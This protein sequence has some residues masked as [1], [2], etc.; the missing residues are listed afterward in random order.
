MAGTPTRPALHS[1]LRFTSDQVITVTKGGANV[2]T[3]S[4]GNTYLGLWECMM[5]I[6]DAVDPGNF[7]VH[8]DPDSYR[9]KFITDAS[10]TFDVSAATDLQA[11]MGL[12]STSYTFSALARPATP[13]S[14]RSTTRYTDHS[15]RSPRSRRSVPAGG[16]TRVQCGVLR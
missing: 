12:S 7:Y 8:C 15:G 10:T 3:L 2:I 13:T 5:L 16:L 1:W 11:L 4:A 6:N 14:Y 9:T